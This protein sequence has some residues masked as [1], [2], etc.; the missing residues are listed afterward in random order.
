VA[1]TR[2]RLALGDVD[3]D[4]TR[5]HYTGT[6]VPHLGPPAVSALL[7]APPTWI[8]HPGVSNVDGSTTSIGRSISMG[9]SSETTLTTTASISLSGGVDIGIVSLSASVTANVEAAS[10]RSMEMEQTTEI[11]ASIGAT[12]DAVQFVSSPFVSYEYVIDTDPDP[13]RV[14]HTFYVDVPQH[15]PA[16]SRFVTL[17]GFRAQF[18]TRADAIIPPSL[19]DHTIGD[20]TTYMAPGE[21]TVAALSAR[22]PGALIQHLLATSALNNVGM[23]TSGTIS[24]SISLSMTTGTSVSLTLG[25]DASVGVGVGGVELEASAGFSTAHTLSTT[26]GSGVAYSATVGNLATGVSPATNYDWGLCVFTFT[27]PGRGSYPVVTY[28]VMQ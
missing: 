28:V 18:P 22:F 11:T 26:L 27:V 25:V 14:G 7:A 13:A 1:G 9:G 4:N 21:C 6:A 17:E 19:F 3:A 10:T 15:V 23:T 20:P 8:G 5:M 16:Q 12:E 24:E 2:V